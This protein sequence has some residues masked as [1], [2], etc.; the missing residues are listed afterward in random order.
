MK[1]TDVRNLRVTLHGDF[2]Q[3]HGCEPGHDVPDDIH[4]ATDNMTAAQLAVFER[5]MAAYRAA[6]PHPIVAPRPEHVF[7]DMDLGDHAMLLVGTG[8]LAHAGMA[9]SAIW[10]RLT[11]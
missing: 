3:P 4:L 2:G 9:I 10:K 5:K 1:Y 11:K 8:G 7:G 6:P